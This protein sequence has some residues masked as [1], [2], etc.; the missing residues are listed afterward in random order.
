[1]IGTPEGVKAM[2]DLLDNDSTFIEFSTSRLFITEEHS[3]F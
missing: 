2:Q 1:L 3:I